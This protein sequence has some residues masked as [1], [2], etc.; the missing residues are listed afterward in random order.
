MKKKSPQE[1]EEL[2]VSLYKVAPEHARGFGCSEDD[3]AKP[4]VVPVGEWQTL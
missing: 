4:V 2:S 1:E 3:C